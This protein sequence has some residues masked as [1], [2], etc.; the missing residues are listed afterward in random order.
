MEVDKIMEVD[1][2]KVRIL[3]RRILAAEKENL[4][5]K[6]RNRDEMARY[7]KKLIEEEVRKCY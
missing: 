6:R 5:T 7:I 3:I 2:K 4:K 1:K